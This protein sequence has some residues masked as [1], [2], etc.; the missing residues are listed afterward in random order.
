MGFLI[1]I[2]SIIVNLFIIY[3]FYKKILLIINEPEK[4]NQAAINSLMIEF[5]K[6]AKNNLDLLEE[7]IFEI[8]NMLQLVDDK[9]KKIDKMDKDL[10]ITKR[11]NNTDSYIKSAGP[12]KHALI[13]KL[14]REGKNS[15]EISKIIGIS[16]AEV[17]LYIN[18]IKK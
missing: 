9:T 10:I 3:F 6:T 13:K 18:L 5:N 1:L 17:D 4:K 14:M 2:I 15:K 7:K 8:K 12:N 11:E 16:K